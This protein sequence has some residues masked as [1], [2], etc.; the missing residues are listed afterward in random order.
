MNVIV[1]PEEVIAGVTTLAFWLDSLPDEAKLAHR[2]TGMILIHNPHRTAG[3]LR[4]LLPADG[5]A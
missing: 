2:D 4:L 3:Y 1:S 5:G